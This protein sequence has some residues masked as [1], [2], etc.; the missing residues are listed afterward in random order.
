MLW[1]NFLENWKSK[2]KQKQNF[3][4]KN[5]SLHVE[6]YLYAAKYKHKYKWYEVKKC[7]IETRW[8][9]IANPNVAQ[10]CV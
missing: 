6:Q 10:S 8:E 5:L 4:N 3:L 7:K 1:A 2:L 9:S